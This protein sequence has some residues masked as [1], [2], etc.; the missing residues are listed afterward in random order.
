VS[1]EAIAPKRP[2]GRPAKAAKAQSPVGYQISAQ[3]K[4]I[5]TT[6]QQFSQK[7][8]RFILATNQIDRLQWPAQKLLTGYK[9]QQKVERGFRFLK[10][11]LFFTSSIFLKKPS[12]VQALALIM[13]L[14][15]LV[16]SLA[17]RKLRQALDQ[18]QQTVLDQ[19]KQPTAKPTFRWVMQKF[20]GIHW[21]RLGPSTQISNLSD[22]RQ[23]IIRLLGPPAQRYYS[24]ST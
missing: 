10:D 5:E 12:R 13:A 7:R 23:L 16:Y 8:S 19:R 3:L 14:T 1:V 4:R 21:V 9:G 2:P 18:Q 15:L 24:G 6:E 20:Q 11:P 22:E 17:E